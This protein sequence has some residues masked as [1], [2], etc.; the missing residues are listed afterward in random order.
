MADVI[1]KWLMELPLQGGGWQMLWPAGRCYLP[2]IFFNFSSEMLNRTSSQMC[3][4]WY[5]PVFLFR[6]GSLC[7]RAQLISQHVDAGQLNIPL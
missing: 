7:A 3:G 5:L 2:G 6:D 1:A 4:R